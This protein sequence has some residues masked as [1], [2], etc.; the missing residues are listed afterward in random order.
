MVAA[1]YT[2]KYLVCRDGQE[3]VCTLRGKFRRDSRPV[4]GDLVDF[5]IHEEGS[6]VITAIHPRRTSLVRRIADRGRAGKALG[7]QVLAANVDQLVIVAAVREPPFRPGLV[8]RFL[9]AAAMAGIDPVI[10]L[11]KAD[12]AEP[13]EMAELAEDYLALK[14]PVFQTSVLQPETLQPLREALG[15]GNSVLVGHSGVGKTSLLN[16]MVGEQMS[17][18]SVADRSKGQGRHT[19]STARLIALAGG[20][21]V[22]DSPGVREFGLHGVAQA[23]LARHYPD[24]VPY[25]GQCGF[26]D[27][28]HRG[29]PGCAVLEAVEEGALSVTRYESY[30]TLL[31]EVG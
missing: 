11:N 21:F 12:L 22:I 1:V 6:G 17:V 26:S 29:E 4:V 16:A 31:E 7:A 14:I 13:G 3:W 24:F 15:N 25:L 19:T 30:L 8:E 2:G 23:D 9:V 10:C 27:C 20:G 18:G 5:E 28:L